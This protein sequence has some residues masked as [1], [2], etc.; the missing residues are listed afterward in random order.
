MRRIYFNTILTS[1]MLILCAAV[2][3]AFAQEQQDEDIGTRGAFLSTRPSGKSS[4]DPAKPNQNEGQSAQPSSRPAIGTA[5]NTSAKPPSGSKSGKKSAA[6]SVAV[7]SANPKIKKGSSKSSS[8]PAKENNAT[9]DS[10]TNF[11]N[12]ALNPAAIGLGYTLY[13]RDANGDA[14][15]VDPK[16][17]FHTGESIRLALESNT[18]GYLY[19][20]HTENDKNPEMIFPDARLGRGSNF[21][22]AHVPYEVP[23]NMEADERLRWFNF[24]GTPATERLYIVLT[25]Q[26]LPDVPTGETLV[27]F[28]ATDGNSC[29]WNPSREMWAQIKGANDREEI[30]VSQLK[31][32][33]RPQTANEREATTR[34]LGLSQDAPGPSIIRMTASSTTGVLVTAVDLMHK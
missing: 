14:L 4:G 11:T 26:P 30:A 17:V 28:C 29:P 25:R 32:A 18:D 20:F 6:G 12:A 2:A 15:R 5:Q 34:G 10:G 24:D 21:V 9:A 1:A 27:K 19:V 23:S 33:G 7:A 3:P 22:R 31:D 13:M 16:R 8:A